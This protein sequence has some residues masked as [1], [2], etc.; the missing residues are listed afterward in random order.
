VLVKNNPLT[1][2]RTSTDNNF[3]LTMVFK[4]DAVERDL[5]VTMTLKNMS[6]ATRTN[7]QLARYADFDVENQAGSN[8][9]DR[10]GHG[11]WARDAT[12]GVTLSALSRQIAHE[13]AVEVAFAS[14]I[15]WTLIA[16]NQCVVTSV[17]VPTAPGDRAGRVT[18]TFGDMPAGS[19]KTVKFAYRRQ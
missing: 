17:A 7:V 1:I 9:Y 15:P 13:T 2:R 3:Q 6:G 18:Y 16:V 8:R 11:V 5:T 14:P 12:Y 19:S 10:S 4:K